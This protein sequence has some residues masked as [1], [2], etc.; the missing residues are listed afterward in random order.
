MLAVKERHITNKLILS[1]DEPSYMTLGRV[2][3]VMVEQGWHT[4]AQQLA[5]DY[6]QL[7]HRKNPQAAIVA[8][9]RMLAPVKL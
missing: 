5:I 6:F 3:G 7:K 8:R 4:A 9:A 2:L 1:K